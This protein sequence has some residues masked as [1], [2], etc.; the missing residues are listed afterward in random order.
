METKQAAKKLP[1]FIRKKIKQIY[2]KLGKLFALLSVW[3]EKLNV[4]Q[5]P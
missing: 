3:E 2:Q 1:E 5:V 4:L